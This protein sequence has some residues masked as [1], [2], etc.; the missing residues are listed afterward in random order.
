MNQGTVSVVALATWAGMKGVCVDVVELQCSC[1]GVIAPRLLLAC[2]CW[3]ITGSVLL[4]RLVPI[5]CWVC[6]LSNRRCVRSGVR[7][8]CPVCY[9]QISVKDMSNTLSCA[10][11]W[12]RVSRLIVVYLINCVLHCRDLVLHTGSLVGCILS[13]HYFIVFIILVLQSCEVM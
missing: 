4:V 13:L 7:G 6:L 3:L 2:L 11:S 12:L 10:G 1:W 8:P 5:R 9:G